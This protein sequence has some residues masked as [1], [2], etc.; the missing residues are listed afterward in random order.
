MRSGRFA[1]AFLAAGWVIALT[2]PAA[3]ADEGWVITSFHSEIS[4]APDSAIVVQEDIRVDFRGLQKHGIFRTIPLRYRYDDTHDRLYHFQSRGVTDGANPVPHTQSVVRDSA[5]IK[6]GD[7]NRLVSGAQRYVI[8]YAI[9]GAMNSFA[10]HDEL[11]W[12]VDGNL[13][14]VPKETVSATVR[15]PAP[16]FRRAA[17]YEG[18]PGST[19]PCE[20][21]GSAGLATYSSTRQLDSGEE[22][23]V[24][25]ALTKGVVTIPPPMLEPRLR[26]FPL[27]AFDINP[28]TVGISALV[29]IAGIGFVAWNWWTHGRDRAYLTHKRS[30]GACGATLQP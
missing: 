23:S 1:V 14:P 11:F 15:L 24:V 4:I 16:A 18:P 20:S 8:T 5:E 30:E 26:Q 29:G 17:C 2:S 19:A 9:F 25:T 7:P 3:H 22:M 10:D 6:I 12:N 13:W 27:D 28:L 21:N